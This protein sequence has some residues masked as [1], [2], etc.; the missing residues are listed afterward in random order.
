MDAGS[1]GDADYGL[2][3]DEGDDQGSGTEGCR[4]EYSLEDEREVVL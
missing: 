2:G 3:Y 1:A 4:E